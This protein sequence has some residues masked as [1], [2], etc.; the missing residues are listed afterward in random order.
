MISILLTALA[1]NVALLNLLDNMSEN[2][3]ILTF[4]RL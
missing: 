1:N 3:T 4:E 2:L